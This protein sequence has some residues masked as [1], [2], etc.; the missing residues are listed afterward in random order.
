MNTIE[1]QPLITVIVPVYKAEL[2]I[3]DCIKSILSQS[4]ENLEVI[5][6]DDGSPDSCPSICDFYAEKDSRVCVIH[7][8]NEGS[9]QARKTG[10]KNASGE[11]VTFVDS[12]DWVD[13]NYIEELYRVIEKNN[14]DIASCDFFYVH[15]KKTFI[16]KEVPAETGM[17]TI[18]KLLEGSLDG[19][20]WLKL[21]KTSLIKENF[22]IDI[23]R[24][25]LW[26]DILT[27][28]ELY[29]YSQQIAYISKPLYYYRYNNQSLCNHFNEKS[30]SD[31]IGVV[32]NVES[33]FKTKAITEVY[34]KNF[35][36]L[37]ARAKTLIL[38]QVQ[39][40]LRK[41]YLSIYPEINKYIYTSSYIPFHNRLEAY[42][43]LNKMPFIGDFLKIIKNVFRKIRGNK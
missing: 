3:H 15:G 35:N 39:K 8:E 22:Y 36:Y 19:Y 33:F 11:Y 7:K 16:K 25:A 28:I 13:I 24:I 38:V 41:K 18:H 34:E 14:A 43:Y 4:Y 27:S 5:I 12:D 21:I 1:D 17:S 2:Y 40:N 30:V 20:T 29:Y 9:Y 32:C 42:F 23:G 10:L 6:V 37:K 26:E 31:L